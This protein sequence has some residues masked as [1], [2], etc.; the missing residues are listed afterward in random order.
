MGERID[1]DYDP[2]AAEVE[3]ISRLFALMA[4]RVGSLHVVDN[5]NGNGFQKWILGIV[6]LVAVMGVGGVIGMFGRLAAVETSLMDLKQQV[7]T[8]ETLIRSEPRPRT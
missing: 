7:T 3:R 6:A 8:L 2:E 1:P 5:S 4:R